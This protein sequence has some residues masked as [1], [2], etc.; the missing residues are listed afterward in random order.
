MESGKVFRIGG[1]NENETVEKDLKS[2]FKMA[3]AVDRLD[4][5]L[6]RRRL[7]V[8][9]EPALQPPL[10]DGRLQGPLP[11]LLSLL[12]LHQPVTLKRKKTERSVRTSVSVLPDLA[13]FHILGDFRLV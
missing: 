12:E 6:L 3:A 4:H 5:V 2:N 13:I 7:V 11:V 8:V 1:R 10:E 9:A